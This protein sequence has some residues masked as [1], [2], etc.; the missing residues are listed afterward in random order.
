MEN[1]LNC[2]VMMGIDKKVMDVLAIA[3]LKRD[4]DAKLLMGYLS[5]RY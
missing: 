1:C 4:G 3:L 2:N 5:V